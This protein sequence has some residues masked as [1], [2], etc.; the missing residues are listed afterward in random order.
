M[1]AA[2]CGKFSPDDPLSVLEVGTIDEPVPPEGWE[3]VDVHAAAL[4]G[5]DLWS[6]RGVGLGQED[7]P[8][9]LGSDGAGM[10]GNRRV[11]LYP[12]VSAHP[13]EEADYLDPVTAPLLSERHDGT[14]AEKVC[15][16]S[17]NLFDVPAHLSLEQAAT[18]PT[19]W[20]TAYRMLF[21]LARLQPGETVLVQGASGG[22]STALVVLGQVAGLRMWV[23]GRS[24]RGR[25]WAL[26]QGAEQVFDSGARLPERVDAVM[27]TVGEATWAH[28]M[29]CVR[30]GGRIIVAGATSGAQPSADL[31][32]LFFNQVQV[33]GARV[34]TLREMRALLRLVEHVQVVPPI[35][36]VFEL[37]ETGQALARLQHGDILGKV[38]VGTRG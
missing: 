30:P 25:A 5:H 24:E 6:L 38:V 9:V 21:T 7:L 32:R 11:V 34:G 8:R 29:R 10:V 26:G 1:R 3:V 14:L 12:I 37:A 35:D 15:V 28:S 18:L 33:R 4:N 19:A 17:Y 16:P 2:Y 36:S 23:T 20:L 31:Q 27:E 13:I 22:V